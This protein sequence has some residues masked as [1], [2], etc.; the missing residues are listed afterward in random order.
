M[1]I[2][3]NLRVEPTGD[4]NLRVTVP[5]VCQVI[6]DAA[7]ESALLKLLTD[8][9]AARLKAN[10]LSKAAARRTAAIN[11]PVERLPVVGPDPAGKGLP[12]V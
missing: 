10:L 4:G 11:E 3:D 6:L 12:D 5:G 9:A 7:A 1:I 8:R 2:G